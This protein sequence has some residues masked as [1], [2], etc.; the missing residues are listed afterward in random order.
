MW[1]MLILDKVAEDKEFR[2]RDRAKRESQ[3]KDAGGSGEI[4]VDESIA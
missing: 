3:R 1:Q 4:M 2:E